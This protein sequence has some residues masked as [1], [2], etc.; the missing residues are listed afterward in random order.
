MTAFETFEG[1]KK[2]GFLALF[3][4]SANPAPLEGLHTLPLRRKMGYNSLVQ[5]QKLNAPLL[6]HRQVSYIH[7][8]ATSGIQTT[9]KGSGMCHIMN[10][11]WW[12]RIQN[13]SNTKHQRHQMFRKLKTISL[14]KMQTIPTAYRPS[15][16]CFFFITKTF[17]SQFSPLF[18]FK[19][20]S[21]LHNRK[22]YFI[23][24]MFMGH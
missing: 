22:K 10:D 23:P 3:S 5:K 6:H 17:L 13:F 21:F 18:K 11:H 9:L 19:N 24:E 7:Q 15:S 8:G 2:F 12:F 14:E 4:Q 20:I 1:V 16:F